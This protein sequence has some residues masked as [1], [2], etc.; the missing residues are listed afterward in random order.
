MRGRKGLLVVAVAV[1]VLGLAACADE[2]AS[3]ATKEEPATLVEI[4]GSDVKQVVL[5]KRAAERIGLEMAPVG[6]TAGAATIPYSAVVYDPEGKTWAFTSPKPLTFM[7][8]P[9]TVAS[10]AGEQAVLSA[11]PAPGTPVVTL[12]TA[13]LYGTENEIGH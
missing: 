9:I 4:K 13:L 11:G 1:A 7:R 2:K 12:G 8:S 10:I 6:G 3:E 5:T